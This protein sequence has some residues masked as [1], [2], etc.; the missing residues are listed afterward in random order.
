MIEAGYHIQESVIASLDCDQIG[1]SLNDASRDE[2]RAGLRNLMSL[3][4]VRDL[5]NS[6][7]LVQLAKE[8]H[9][10]PMIPYKATLFS[11][12]G[13][14]NWLVAWH[15]DTALPLERFEKREGWGAT[16][17]KGGIL[18]AQAPSSALEK[19]IALRIHLDSSTEQN[20]PL[21]VLPGSH[22]FGILSGEQIDGMSCDTGGVDCLVGKGG[23]IAM[24]PLLLHASSK[25]VVDLPRRVLHIEYA[26]TL[27]L[28]PGTRLAIA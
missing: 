25:S 2:R 10:K 1:R 15:Q 18:F 23:V 7:C 24:S 11:K 20:G 5:A 14:A 17:R 8:I 19:V 12:T 22:R 3:D 9:G 26:E 21:R 4:F 6:E 28:E 27:V 16:S 13:K